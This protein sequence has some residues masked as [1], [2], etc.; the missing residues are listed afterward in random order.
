MGSQAQRDFQALSGHKSGGA[1]PLCGGFWA[2]DAGRA[3][4]GAAMRASG[5]KV[6][7]KGLDKNIAPP[8]KTV[9]PERVEGR[10]SV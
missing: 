9:S 3:G 2:R 5:G 8:P 1:F 7:W 10:L 4:V 6:R